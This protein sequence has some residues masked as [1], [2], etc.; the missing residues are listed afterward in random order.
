MPWFKVC[1]KVTPVRL[2]ITFSSTKDPPLSAV[3]FLLIF[4]FLVE[5]VRTVIISEDF[6]STSV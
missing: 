4:W 1:L 5:C 2:N 6:A 3:Y